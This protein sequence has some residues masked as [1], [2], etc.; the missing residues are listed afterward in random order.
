VVIA[1]SFSKVIPYCIETQLLQ[2]GGMTDVAGHLVSSAGNVLDRVLKT[3]PT[4]EALVTVDARLSYEELDFAIERAAR[5][6]AGLGVK[7]DDVVAVSLPNACDVVVT[8]HAIMRLGAI[9]LGVNRNLAPPEKYY[10]LNDAGTRLLLSEVELDN[11]DGDDDRSL[12]TVLVGDDDGAWVDLID[13]GPTSYRRPM[14]RGT[15]PAGIAYT[16]GTTGRPKGVVHSHRNILLPGAMLVSARGFGPELRKGDCAALTILNMQITS[17]LLVAQAGGTQIVMD[18]VDPAGVAGWVKRE[19]VN[20]WFG[21]PTILYGLAENHDVAADDL[22]S[23]TDVWTGGTYLAEPIRE[24]FEQRFGCRVSATYGLTEAPTVVTIEDRTEDRVS[25]SSGTALPHLVVEIRSDTGAVLPVGELGEITI[26]ANPAGPWADLYQPMLGYLSHPD[27]TN[28]TLRNA[29]LYTGDIGQL[30]PE[31]HLFVRD[32][33]NAVILRG[34]ANVYPA[35]VER[36]LLEAPGV[37]GASV[38]GVPDERLGQ[39]VAAAVETESGVSVDLQTL[40]EFCAAHLARYKVP[41][42]WKVAPLPRNAMGKV[43]RTEIEQ[44]FASSD[45][46]SRL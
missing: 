28:N 21:V 12:R 9:W 20:S 15:D 30:D 10:I 33:R 27:A 24:S 8:F 1:F 13:H 46:V 40:S 41:D 45:G 25:E 29:V 2:R 23:L 4:R 37:K 39:R 3:D 6:L 42:F 17:T 18:R 14:R 11:L 16:S 43:V 44:W 26:R 38:I 7:K 32:R 31:G 22:A 5:A 36:V 19:S 35:E 34:G